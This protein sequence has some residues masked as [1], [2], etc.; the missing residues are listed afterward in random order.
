MAGWSVVAMHEDQLDVDEAIARRLLDE[1]FPQ[2]RGWPV[3]M[4][5]TA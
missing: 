2:W 5:T 3:R 1:Q 4:L